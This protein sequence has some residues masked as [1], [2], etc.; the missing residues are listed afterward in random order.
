MA[1]LSE[2]PQN[3]AAGNPKKANLRTVAILVLTI[4][5]ITITATTFAAL[6]TSNNLHSTGSVKATANLGLY[7]DSACQTPLTSI[8]W[9]IPSPGTSVTRVIY[10]KNTG[11]GI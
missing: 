4:I 3:I 9:G 11:S 2:M 8:D 7:S 5:A 1:N 10:I 6:T